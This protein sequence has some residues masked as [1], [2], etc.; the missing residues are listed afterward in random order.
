MTDLRTLARGVKAP[1]DLVTI[2][3]IDDGMVKRG[4]PYPLARTDLANI[5]DAIAQKNPKLIAV[6]LLLVD[7]GTAD[8]DAALAKSFATRPPVLAAAAIFSETSQPVTAGS[9]GPLGRLPKADR[10]LQPLKLFA[11]H[12]QVGIANVATTESWNSLRGPNAVSDAGPGR[13]VARAARCG[14]RDR[15]TADDRA[16][17]TQIR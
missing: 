5:I 11:D 7:R 17:P 8:G 13:V 16:V 2:V 10:F 3:A 4:S 14:D 15:Q 12:A 1:P 9:D 6:D